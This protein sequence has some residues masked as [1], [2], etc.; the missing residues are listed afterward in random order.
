MVCNQQHSFA[1]FKDI[2]D[3]K[4][5]LL[6]SMHKKLSK[7]RKKFIKLNEVNPQTE[8]NKNLK[9]KILDN[10]GDTFN[11]LYYISKKNMKKKKML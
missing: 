6:D 5:M 2:S 8:A 1:K 10:A 7:F 3:F 11:E 4:E 9:T